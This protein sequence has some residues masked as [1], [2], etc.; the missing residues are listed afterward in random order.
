MLMYACPLL[1]FSRKNK[2]LDFA[3]DYLFCC[4]IFTFYQET[5][6]F[7]DVKS[8]NYQLPVWYGNGYPLAD[9]N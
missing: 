8:I 5:A 7:S 1:F 3:G 4:T 2:M 9:C 6:G